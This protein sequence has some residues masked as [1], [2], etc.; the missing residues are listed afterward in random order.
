MLRPSLS[1]L[2][3]RD[4]SEWPLFVRESAAACTYIDLLGGLDWA[5]FPERGLGEKRRGPHPKADAPV[6]AAFLVKLD[7]GF[8]SMK[9]LHDY[10]VEQ[11]ALVWVLG[12]ALVPSDHYCYGF[13]VR[14][15][16]PTHRHLSRLLR[17][18][19]NA[20]MQFLLKGTLHLLKA[21]LPAELRFGEEISLD[22][23]QIIA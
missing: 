17:K 21:E 1:Q 8:E 2:A 9:D 7:K 4:Q 22:T 6:V 20:Q 11:P 13:D 5:H 3:Q 14:Q 15:S 16:L 19:P 10:L 12:F 23:K 18:L